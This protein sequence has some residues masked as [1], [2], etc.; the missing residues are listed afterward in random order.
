MHNSPKRNNSPK[1]TQK[2]PVS[3]FLKQTVRDLDQDVRK[4]DSECR[5]LTS[6]GN[7]AIRIRR[8]LGKNPD[9]EKLNKLMGKPVNMDG[10]PKSSIVRM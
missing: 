7:S 8:V 3:K 10:R 4:I 9:K 2:S 6:T 1:R 5:T